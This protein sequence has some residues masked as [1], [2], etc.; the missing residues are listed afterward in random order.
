MQVTSKKLLVIVYLLNILNAFESR[1][2]AKMKT[3]LTGNIRVVICA[4]HTSEF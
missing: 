2:K 3:G 4:V 1:K